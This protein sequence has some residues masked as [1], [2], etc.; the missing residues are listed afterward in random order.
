MRKRPFTI[1]YNIIHFFLFF[2]LGF[3]P[4]LSFCNTTNNRD[5]IK[6]NSVTNSYYKLIFKA[7]KNFLDITAPIIMI[8]MIINQSPSSSS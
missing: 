4:F 1:F 7:L 5:V 3:L 6:Y 2:L 8:I